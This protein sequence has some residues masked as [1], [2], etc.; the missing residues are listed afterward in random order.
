MEHKIQQSITTTLLIT[1]VIFT[2][3]HPIILS[4]NKK[5]FII[6]DENEL[7]SFDNENPIQEPTYSE[8]YSDNVEINV[9]FAEGYFDGYNLFLYDRRNATDG[10]MVNQFL[11]IT[12]MDGNVI[13]E[14]QVLGVV[15]ASAPAEFINSTTIMYG[16]D[17]KVSFW[18]LEN[19][20]TQSFDIYGHHEYEY[21]PIDDTIFTLDKREIIIDSTLW[22]HDYI[23]E[24]N[25]EGDLLWE[26]DTSTFIPTEY[27]CPYHDMY[28]E[29]QDITHTNSIVYDPDEDVL[30]VNIRNPNTFYKINHSNGEIIWGL[31]EYGDFTLFDKYGNEK[32]SLFYHSHAVELVGD[33]TF[34]MFDNDKHNQSKNDNYRSRI[35]EISINETTMTA[36]ET[37][38]WAGSDAYYSYGYG[39]A[40]RLPNGNRLGVFGSRSHPGE[41]NIGGR[42]VEVNSHGEVVWELNFPNSP[43]Y[44]HGVYRVERFRFAPILDSPSDIIADSKDNISVSWKGWYNYRPKKLVT[45]Q[46]TLVLDDEVLD[47][48]LIDYDKFWRPTELNFELGQLP[49]GDHNLTLRI[50]DENGKYTT[51]TINI[52][53]V[54]F[55]LFRDSPASFEAGQYKTNITWYGDTAAPLFCNITDNDTLLA[56]F[57]WSGSNITLDLSGLDL[58]YHNV[59]LKLFNLTN[60]VKKDTFLIPVY[61]ATPPSILRLHPRIF[62]V[63]WNESV[64]LSWQIFDYAPESWSIYLNGTLIDTGEW[65]DYDYLLEWKPSLLNESIYN[66]T[67][68][69]YDQGGQTTSDISWLQILPPLIPVIDSVTKIT[70]VIWGTE[71]VSLFWGVHGG[72]TWNLYRN[73]SRINE[74]DSNDNI[75]EVQITDWRSE[76]WRLGKYNLTLLIQGKNGSAV[77]MIWL[78]I[79]IELSDPYVD[80]IVTESSVY[81]SHAEYALGAP[82]G[83]FARIYLD[84]SNGRIVFDMGENEEIVNSTGADFEIIARGGNYTVI[85]GSSSNALTTILG[86]G[87]GNQ[88]FDLGVA[89]FEEVRFLA[90]EFRDGA[91]VEVDAIY[92]INYIV[93]EADSAK[94]EIVPIDDFWVWVNESAIDLTWSASDE[95]SWNYSVYINGSLYESSPWNGSDIIIGFSEFEVGIWNITL[96]VFDLFD[97][98]E[99]D[100]VFIEVRDIPNTVTTTTNT[101]PNQLQIQFIIGVI[102][103]GLIFSLSILFFSFKKRRS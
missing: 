85:I 24:Y 37:W 39:D 33:N 87:S 79:V 5:R 12:D 6:T 17:G 95:T 29:A 72:I 19:N 66:I 80:N 60:L 20:H 2:M 71:N 82:D 52:S 93:V 44:R 32:N 14:R 15:I 89:G 75:I 81:Y 42:I 74:G 83:Q 54:G 28:G 43:E 3:L 73:G 99:R 58:G 61:P 96:V 4:G 18:N 101:N 88:S 25:L 49:I 70:S 65:I 57:T 53:I 27:W 84:Y 62:N 92:A 97:N 46:Y 16:D 40:D 100:I 45:C 90:I 26:L 69:L 59:T 38:S 86:Y 102:I 51:D 68:I 10:S 47:S 50:S 94:P 98:Y 103:L 8:M 7:N 78:N 31:G 63:T 91:T 55:Y 22:R 48:G 21:N 77:S 36:N 35:L 1:L 11:V 34:I 23:R 76:K 41:P 64:V 56:S 9:T 13:R 67:V 30:Y